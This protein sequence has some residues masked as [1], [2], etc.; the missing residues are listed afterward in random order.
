[1]WRTLAFYDI[2]AGLVGGLLAAVPGLI[3]YFTLVGRARTIGTYHMAVN[4]ATLALFA[5]S[6]VLRTHWG[7]PWV[8][9]GSNLPQALTI[10]GAVLLGVGGWLGGQLVYVHGVG[11]E[12]VDR[13][14]AEAQEAKRR[15][16]A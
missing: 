9:A 13:A 12:A 14:Q 4:V 3:D 10:I 8:P 5:V 16:A 7:A 1:M 2:A 6:F 15:R 11:V